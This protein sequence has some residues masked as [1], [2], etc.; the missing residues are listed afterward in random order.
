MAGRAQHRSGS[1]EPRL[2]EQALAERDRLGLPE[3]RLVPSCRGAGGQGPCAAMRAALRGP[4]G[5]RARAQAEREKGEG[6][7]RRAYGVL[8][9][10]EC[11]SPRRATSG[12]V[13]RVSRHWRAFLRWRACRGRYRT[14]VEERRWLTQADFAETIGLCQFLP[15]PNIGNASSSSASAGS[16]CPARSSRSSG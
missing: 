8:C 6:Q 14:M 7:R 4:Y 13:P 15:G 12:A 5:L 11:R 9:R 16:A 1:R 10:K 2:E 3:T